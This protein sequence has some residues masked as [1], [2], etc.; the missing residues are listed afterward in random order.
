MNAKV[1]MQRITVQCLGEY[2]R[3]HALSVEQARVCRHMQECQTQVLGGLQW[4]CD[5]CDYQHPEFHSCRDRH[6]P[7]C[8]W[9]AT[10]AWR[11][12]Q[13]ANVLPVSYFHV[14][15]T[16]PHQL[17]G[18][19]SLHPEVIYRCFFAAVWHTLNAFGQDPK[20]LGGQLGV[21]AVLHT[22][23]QNLSRH[24]HIHCLIPG[25]AIDQKGQW[26][27]TKGGHDYLFPNRALSRHVRGNMVSRLRQSA[28]NG[29]LHRITRADE[30][31]VCLTELMSVDWVVYSKPYLRNPEVIVDYLA[32]YTH[33]IALDNRRL[34]GIKDNQVLLS[35]K[36]YRDGDKRKVLKL[37]AE[38]LLRRFLLHVLPKGLMRI[39]H[40]GFLANCCREKK[41]QQIR[42]SLAVPTK[43]T[44]Q[45]AAD[46]E[47]PFV[48][49]SQ[50]H[51]P[52]CQQGI[53]M[54]IYRYTSKYHRRE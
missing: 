7:Q 42:Q 45:E 53:L 49:T 20:R 41:L 22:W 37:D 54:V 18:W 5:Q 48:R 43:V 16:L 35:Y 2:E 21:V 3:R 25:G 15:F 28:K 29:E 30:I 44:K 24:V 27:A 19:V 26:H 34:L 38:E 46:S 14:V 32:R 6:C 33:R 4:C 17:N 39:R 8:Q 9:R 12:K 47:Q 13:Q 52:R 11:D 31:D 40:F 36:D 1:S 50:R 51:C 23:G 10:Q